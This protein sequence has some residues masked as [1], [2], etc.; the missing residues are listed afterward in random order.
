MRRGLLFF[1]IAGTS[2]SLAGLSAAPRLQG[3]PPGPVSFEVASGTG[4][5]PFAKLTMRRGA[6]EVSAETS[7]GD[8]PIDAA[9]LTAERITGLKLNCKDFQVRSTS[10]GHDAQADVTLVI[11]HDGETHRGRGV[12]TD[13]VEATVKALLNAANRVALKKAGR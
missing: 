4:R 9:F 2:A 6:E 1:L 12:S 10:L 11:E 13:S 3:A 7:E 8:G 5:K